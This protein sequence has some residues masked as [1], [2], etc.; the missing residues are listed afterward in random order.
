MS[1][2][3]NPGV[4][5]PAKIRSW[6]GGDERDLHS[7]HVRC[8]T[9]TL[10]LLSEKKNRTEGEGKEPDFPKAEK[11]FILNLRILNST[12]SRIRQRTTE[13]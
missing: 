11:E 9:Q 2:V 3:N 10:K 6:F 8:L 1:E 4:P 13:H 7:F 5:G 12:V